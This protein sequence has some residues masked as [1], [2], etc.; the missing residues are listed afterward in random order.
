MLK[1]II[2][3]PVILV[4]LS[5]CAFADTLGSG[6]VGA[7]C[8]GRKGN[9]QL[10]RDFEADSTQFFNITDAAESGLDISGNSELY[11]YA[12]VKFESRSADRF[13]IGKWKADTGQRQY[14]LIYYFTGARFAFL[15]SG[16]GSSATLL[17]ASTFGEP[18]N[19][20]WYFVRF[21]HNPTTDLIGI[22]INNGPWDTTAHSTGI[23]DG[24]GDFYIGGG[25]DGGGTNRVFDGLI[26]PAAI[27]S[28]INDSNFYNGGTAQVYSTLK[29]SQKTGLVSYWNLSETAGNA[30]DA[31]STNNLTDNNSVSSATGIANDCQFGV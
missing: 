14:L 16:N 20:V 24:S 25:I 5:S 27:Y 10:A 28:S 22:S 31:Y 21:Y 26:G 1:R 8:Y 2:P 3:I 15:V 4:L 29:P 13:I 6:S 7:G 23:F 9:V 17:Q 11:G 30:I 19:G 18:A 12:W